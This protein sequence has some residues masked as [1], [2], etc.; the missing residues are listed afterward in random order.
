MARRNTSSS[1]QAVIFDTDVLVHYARGER[2]AADFIRSVPYSLR[3][4]SVVVYM[5][6]LQGA[7][8]QREM[9]I[10]RRDIHR[11]FS[12]VLAV[13]EAISHQATRL[14]ERH[15]LP[16]GLRVADA[17]IAATALVHGFD[18]ATADERHYRPIFKAE[19]VSPLTIKGQTQIVVCI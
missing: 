6:L 2:R 8:D 16:H 9:N 11:N 17:L 4:I 3:K 15:A 18:L 19:S 13:H 10:L 14:M 5:E 12:E 7:R 1:L